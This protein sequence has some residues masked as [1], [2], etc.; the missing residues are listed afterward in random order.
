M[1]AKIYAIVN[2]K[3]GVGKTTTAVNLGASLAESGKRVLIIDVDPQANATSGVGLKVAEI[4]KTLFDLLN[5]AVSIDQT[6]YPTS[7]ENLH[8]IPA[9]AD[10]SGAVVTLLNKENREYLLKDALVPVS[11]LYD[12]IL[13]DCPPSLGILTINALAAAQKIMVPVQCEY[14]AMEG[15]SR[16]MD[17]VELM[18]RDV[19]PD[20]ELGGIILTMFDPRTKLNQ[21]V[22]KETRKHFTTLVFDSIIPRNVRISEAPSFGQPISVYAKQSAGADAYR[23]LAKEVI[24]N[25]SK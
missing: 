15:L 24:A 16:L 9:G 11:D 13:M 20:L 8:V 5:D 2:Q 12:F 19:N 3:G 17:L 10:L 14:Y 6:I 25:E 22:V 7:V 1:T 4:D 18:K 23:K 21:E